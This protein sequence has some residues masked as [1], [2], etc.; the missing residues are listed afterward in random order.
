LKIIIKLLSAITAL[1]IPLSGLLSAKPVLPTGMPTDTVLTEKTAVSASSQSGITTPLP[2]EISNNGAFAAVISVPPVIRVANAGYGLENQA[3]TPADCSTIQ[4]QVINY[5]TRSMQSYSTTISVSVPAGASAP[6]LSAA[7][8]GAGVINIAPVNQS[9]NPYTWQI[10]GGNAVAGNYI[11]YTITYTLNGRQ[12]TQKAASAIDLVELGAG[13]QTYVVRNNWAGTIRTRHEYTAV[14]SGSG[15]SGLG[16]SVYGGGGT[17]YYKM[18]SG[19]GSTG[20]VPG[21]AGY[22][23]MRL[24]DPGVDG[25]KNVENW[26]CGQSGDASDNNGDGGHRATL[27]VYYDPAI[28]TNISQLGIKL[29]Y[30]RSTSPDK[31]PTVYQEKMI[32]LPGTS[33]FSNTSTSNPTAQ[34]YFYSTNALN[35]RTQG[36]STNPGT[37]TFNFASTAIPPDGQKVT[38]ASGIFGEDGMPLFTWKAWTIT[39]YVM[40]KSALRALIAAEDAA[41]RQLHDGY[42]NTDGS[43]TAYL[44]QLAKSKAVLNQPNATPAQINAAVNDL[45]TTKNN[46]KYAQANYASLNTLVGNIYSASLGFR[47]SL[48][49]D[50]DYYY[51]GVNFYPSDYYFST[52]GLQEALAG[53][54]YG[55]D[56]RYQAYVNTIT[57]QVNTAWRSIELLSADYSIVNSH[58]YKISGLNDV[59]GSE[60]GNYILAN[61]ANYPQYAG[62]MMYWRDFTQA[63]YNA[64]E[65]AVY[66]VTLGLKIPDQATVAAMGI[67]LQTTH[68]GLV[69]KPA[70]YSTLDVVRAAALNAVNS[71]VFVQDPAGE[72][73]QISLYSAASVNAIE[74]KLNEIVDGLLIPEQ[75]SVIDWTNELQVVLNAKTLNGA[76]YSYANTQKAIPADYEAEAEIYYTVA[77][78]QTLLDARAAVLPGK[79]ADEQGVVNAWALQIYNTRNA[80][81]LNPADYTAVHSIVAAANMLNSSLYQNWA[82]VQNTIDSVIYGL[83]IDE[84]VTVDAHA[85]A[86]SAAVDGLIYL[87]A[88]LSALTQALFTAAGYI[89]GVYTPASWAAFSAAVDDAQ[90]ILNNSPPFNITRQAEVDAAVQAITDMAAALVEAAV[91][92]EANPGNTAVI[93]SVRGYIYGLPAD[94]NLDN[95]ILR[96]YLDITGNGHFVYTPTAL[97]F[98]TGTKVEFVR[99]ADGKVMATYFIVIFGD[100]DGDGLADARDA[101]IASM[102][103]AG[104]LTQADI[105]DTA[106]YAADANHDGIVE[107]SDV[108][109]LEQAGLFFAAVNQN[110]A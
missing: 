73:H 44:N 98:G 29:F 94:G 72:G 34:S 86:I 92:F 90:S 48:V 99:D 18:S 13:W 52:S 25:K 61:S 102:L 91:T 36:I 60:A 37:M 9:G 80:L 31:M 22:S 104:M 8:Q 50:P 45:N 56:V 40:N 77:S 1:L 108:L 88:D 23:G 21:A 70:D 12:Y 96:D 101:V 3:L 76:D 84:Q 51:S 63:S 47:P 64:W 43:F 109:L 7:T 39:F 30:W 32:Y 6:T 71:S 42:T 15:S 100:T 107:S 87:D 14:L 65:T 2:E 38:F 95:L 54:V 17:G 5:S 35:N 79:L 85:S 59:T 82:T 81:V 97:G 11:E 69:I 110:P 78:L 27:D 57:G 93:D 67:A 46:F 68:A 19:G 89:E 28:I 53:A 24:W 41:F 10:T 62:Q 74:A 16:Y 26:Y 4:T 75:P 49:N 103:T 66:G 20:F 105:G 58:L 33:L 55:L 106:Y 83:K